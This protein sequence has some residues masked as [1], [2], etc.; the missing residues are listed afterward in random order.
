MP[1]VPGAGIGDVFEGGQE[2]MHGGDGLRGM[3]PHR[4]KY[5]S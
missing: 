2:Q 3:G 4:Q 5:P 1:A